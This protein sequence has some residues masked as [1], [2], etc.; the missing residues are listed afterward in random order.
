[1]KFGYAHGNP[2][3]SIVVL[4]GGPRAWGDVKALAKEIGPKFGVLEPYDQGEKIK[5][6]LHQLQK[7]IRTYGNPPMTIIGHSWGAWI[8]VLFGASYPALVKKV[9]LIGAGPFTSDLTHQIDQTRQSRMNSSERKR[10]RDFLVQDYDPKHGIPWEEMNWLTK[11]CKKLDLYEPLPSVNLSRQTNEIDAVQEILGKETQFKPFMALNHELE[12]MRRDGKLIEAMENV[13]CPVVAIHG[14]YDSHPAEAV[15]IAVKNHA[16]HGE[17][18]LLPKCGHYPWL[19]VH[20]E[21]RFYQILFD[22]LE[23][24]QNQTM[25]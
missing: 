19:E 21:K 13:E 25:F 6:S 22:Q 15:E 20:A 4:H 17:F 8:A 5:S 9:I 2:P 3:Y 23:S 10:Y 16:K 12:L 11:F 1:M 7:I 14:D 24:R 18:Y